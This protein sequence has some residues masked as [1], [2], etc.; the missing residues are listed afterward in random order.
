MGAEDIEKIKG[1][2]DFI[3]MSGAGY[4]ESTPHGA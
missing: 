1:K 2:A 4:K 3:E